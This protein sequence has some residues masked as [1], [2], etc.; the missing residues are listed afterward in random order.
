MRR[1]GIGNSPARFFRRPVAHTD[2]S[3]PARTTP[4]H[5]CAIDRASSPVVNL[6]KVPVRHPCLK[7][8]IGRYLV[9]Y[10]PDEIPGDGWRYGTDLAYMKELVAYWRDRYD[11]R[12]HEAKLNEPPQFTVPLGGI[13]LH[14][15]HAEGVGPRPLPLL[16]SHGWPGS[17]WEFH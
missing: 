15:I 16:L 12:T 1:R 11:W 14:F 13:D 10:R 6:T 17:V 9:R 8:G 2:G 4:T 3:S 5:K 7:I